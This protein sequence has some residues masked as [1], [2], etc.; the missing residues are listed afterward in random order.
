MRQS[1]CVHK[2]NSGR[3]AS[4]A[5]AKPHK[6]KQ[7]QDVVCESIRRFNRPS[8][9]PHVFAAQHSS[10][11]AL[12]AVHL[13]VAAFA[14]KP[15]PHWTLADPH[16][17]GVQHSLPSFLQVVQVVAAAFATKPAAQVTLADPHVFAGGVQRTKGFQMKSIIQS[18]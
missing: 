5:A 9:F 17:F 3:F 6:S 12:Q 8:G 15:A 4:T 7:Q 13:R 2:N 1:A 10:P 11:S 14:T 18:F 16:V